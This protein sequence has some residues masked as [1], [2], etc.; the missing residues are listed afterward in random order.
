[1]HDREKDLY[2]QKARQAFVDSLNKF[3]E[4]LTSQDDPPAKSSP[5]KSQ[6]QS[7]NTQSK[8]K[9]RFTLQDLEEA[10]AD[11]DRYMASLHHEE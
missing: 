2:K 6:Q 3:E 4:T 5:A 1:M 7:H 10:A 8:P 9:Q 11:I